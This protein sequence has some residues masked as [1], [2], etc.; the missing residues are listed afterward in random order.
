MQYVWKDEV[1]LD[2]KDDSIEIVEVEEDDQSV[3]DEDT[4]MEPQYDG[5]PEAPC[6]MHVYRYSGGAVDGPVL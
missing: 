3:S 6:L 2:P 4:G 1:D 5:V